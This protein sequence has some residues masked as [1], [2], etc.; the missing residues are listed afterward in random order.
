[1]NTETKILGIILFA[2]VVLIA[3]AVFFL[4]RGS[5]SSTV[6]EET[7]TVQI[8]YSKGEKIGSDSAKVKVVEFSDLQCPSCLT[9]EPFVRKVRSTQNVQLIYRHFPLTRHIYG[10]KVANLAEAAGE[11]GKFWEMHDKLFDT[12]SQWSE[13]SENDAMAF[14]LSLAKD[15]GLDENKVKDE[16]ANDAFKAKIDADLAEGQRLGVD[17]TPTFFVNGHKLDLANYSDLNTAVENELKK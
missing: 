11:Q 12:Q 16:I 2:T 10:K 9:A 6:L 5:N 1:M 14:F 4:G 3:G 13:M 7:Q 8:D 17:A 15:L